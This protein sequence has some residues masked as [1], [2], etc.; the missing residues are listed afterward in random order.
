MPIRVVCSVCQL[1]SAAP[2]SLAGRSAPCLSCGNAV[3][4]PALAA[5]APLATAPLAPRQRAQMLPSR[6]FQ[7]ATFPRPHASSTI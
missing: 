1:A 7:P 6:S 2:E 4:I 3:L 5:P